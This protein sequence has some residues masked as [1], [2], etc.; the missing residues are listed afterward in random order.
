MFVL[1]L[2]AVQKTQSPAALFND[3]IQSGKIRNG[4][5]AR[6]RWLVCFGCKENFKMLRFPTVQKVRL[7]LLCF[8]EL[9][10]KHDLLSPAHMVVIVYYCIYFVEA[11]GR[12]HGYAEFV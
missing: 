5:M 12:S 4:G 7:D 10:L 9:F 2:A 3:Q 8:T 11:R 1:Q 6:W